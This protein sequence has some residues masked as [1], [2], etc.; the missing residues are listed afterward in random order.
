MMSAATFHSIWTLIIFICMI[1]IIFWAYSRRQKSA[2]E[3]AA[4]LVFADET[5]EKAGED[6]Q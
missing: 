1:G 6:K 5:R 3:E 2:F 4:N